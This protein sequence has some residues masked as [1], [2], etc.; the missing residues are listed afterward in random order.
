MMF[1]IKVFFLPGLE[2]TFP[3]GGWKLLM[4]QTFQRPEGLGT[5]EIKTK[6]QSFG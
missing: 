1:S 3:D 6:A 2:K 5:F 4:P